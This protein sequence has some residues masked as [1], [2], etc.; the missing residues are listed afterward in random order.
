MAPEADHK[1]STS[2]QSMVF[3]K[4]SN[5]INRKRIFEWMRWYRRRTLA[6][7]GVFVGVFLAI[8]TVYESRLMEMVDGFGMDQRFRHR[9]P[10][11]PDPRIVIVAIDNSAFNI[12]ESVPP[13]STALAYEPDYQYLAPTWP[14]NRKVLARAAEKLIAAGARVVGIDLV[15]LN[16]GEGD[17]DFADMLERIGDKV[18]IASIFQEESQPDGKVRLVEYFPNSSILPVSWNRAESEKIIGFANLETDIDGRVRVLYSQEFA[19][20]AE[21]NVQRSFAASIA[22][23]FTRTALLPALKEPSFINYTGPDGSHPV[24]LFED[25]FLR[26]GW[27]DRL[28]NG[29]VFRDK[30]VLIAPYSFVRFKDVHETPFDRMHGPEI[31]ANMISTLLDGSALRR[32]GLW[33]TGALIIIFVGAVLIISTGVRQVM[34]RLFLLAGLGLVY[35][36]GSQIIFNKYG[37]DL[38]FSIFVIGYAF[39]GFLFL[40][41]DLILEQYERHRIKNLF[42]NYVSEA[43]V[44]EMVESHTDPK[45]GGVLREVTCFFSDVESFSTFSELM[46]PE[47]LVDLMNEYLT[48]MT[49]VLHACGGTLDKYIGDAIVAMFGAPLPLDNHALQACRAAV[50]MQKVQA[51]LRKRWA[52]EH[53]RWPAQCRQMRTRIGLNTGT[54]TVGNMGSRTRFNYTFMGDQVNLAARCESAA[55]HYG[56]YTL[57]SESTRALAAPTA[58]ELIFRPLDRIIVKGRKEPVTIHELMGLRGDLPPEVGELLGHWSAAMDCYLAGDWSKAR[59]LFQLTLGLEPGHEGSDRSGARTPSSVMA[60]RCAELLADPPSQPWTGIWE[61]KSK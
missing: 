25:L 26:E 19:A 53:T 45:L 12:H 48:D 9:G 22:E 39:P 2:G 46:G 31:Q 50:E 57:V 54:V 29:D 34:P 7:L 58:P 16:A 30:A 61:M 13:D 11:P 15:M 6:V 52:E 59:H 38:G 23:R 44:D 24:F 40:L 37:L 47:Q 17:S 4:V 55:K 60:Q 10:R 27:E 14:W 1:D 56:V 28:G 41:H 49:D 8:G 20:G 5:S 43:V 32:P 18:V 21:G 35:V 51:V 3:R 36:I 33:A 42:G